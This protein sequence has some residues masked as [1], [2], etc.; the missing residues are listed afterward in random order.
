M[1]NVGDI[2]IVFAPRANGE[3]IGR[4]SF[5]VIGNEPGKILGMDYDLL[6]IIMSSMDSKAKREKMLK[7]PGNISIMPEDRDVKNDNGKP[8][9]AKADQIFHFETS[10]TDYKVIGKVNDDI[11]DLLFEFIEDMKQEGR[12]AVPIIDN[13]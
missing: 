11:V 6:C 7:Y 8:A 9:F 12:K 4:H 13:L 1:P 10:K 2:I 3:D 5:I